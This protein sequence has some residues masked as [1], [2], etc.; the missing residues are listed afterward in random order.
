MSDFPREKLLDE[1]YDEKVNS[2]NF[3]TSDV[4]GTPENALVPVIFDENGVLYTAKR[5]NRD[6]DIV[7]ECL[8]EYYIS[9]NIDITDEMIND[10]FGDGNSIAYYTD[11]QTFHD[12]TM[13]NEA[14]LDYVDVLPNHQGK[15]I[16]SCDPYVIFFETT[17]EKL[18][19]A[20]QKIKNHNSVQALFVP[21]WARLGN[22]IFARW[23]VGGVSDY[24][25]HT[26]GVSK[27][28]TVSGSVGYVMRY[29]KTVEASND[30]KNLAGLTVA[31]TA[32][33][34]FE[35]YMSNSEYDNWNSSYVY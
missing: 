13:L 28:P 14:I 18:T 23:D 12:I 10:W 19:Q 11:L 3:T 21:S 29:T 25:G 33:G 2:S 4:G 9:G 7:G 1:S 15:Q 26:G 22:I 24:Y 6:Q 20:E 16:R 31:G 8:K 17:A 27:E 35:K 34:V 32:D 30:G 5:L